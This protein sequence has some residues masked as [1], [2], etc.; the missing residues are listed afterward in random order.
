MTKK[1]TAVYLTYLAAAL[2]SAVYYI[3]IGQGKTYVAFFGI[4][5]VLVVIA[6]IVLFAIVR[7][8]TNAPIF[9][10]ALIGV[11]Q[12]FPLIGAIVLFMIPH[13]IFHLALILWSI[14]LFAITLRGRAPAA[15]Q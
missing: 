12:I 13:T 8:R 1:Q 5:E 3:V 11:M 10:C 14:A 4:I 7:T 9:T 15:Q 2:I 6:A